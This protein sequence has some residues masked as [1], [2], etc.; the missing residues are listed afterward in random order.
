MP[1]AFAQRIPRPP[2]FVDAQDCR[3]WLAALSGEHPARAH[4]A[5]VAESNLL[6]AQPLAP[7]ERL[8]ILELLREAAHRACSEAARRFARRALPLAASEKAAFDANVALARALA[9]GYAICLEAGA[10]GQSRAPGEAALAAQRSLATLA[11]EQLDA[12]RTGIESAPSFWRAAHRIYSAAEALGVAE[13]AVEDP[14]FDERAASPAA[15][16]AYV[17]LLHRCDAHELEPSEFESARRHLARWSR[18]LK[19]SASPPPF[20]RLP[21]LV[22]DCAGSRP[23]SQVPPQAGRLRYLDTAPLAAKLKRRLQATADGAARATH[24]PEPGFWRHLYEHCCKGALVRLPASGKVGGDCRLVTGLD[25]AHYYLSGRK[26]F[27]EPI[28]E[29]TLA[30]WE[31]E[32]IA[33]LRMLAPRV[34]NGFSRS[35]GFQVETWQLIEASGGELTLFRPPDAPGRLG[36]G[37]LVAIKGPPDEAYVLAR[38]HWVRLDAQGAT[39]ARVR[40]IPG[41]P[42]PA[43]IRVAPAA[44]ADGQWRPGFVVTGGATPSL[45]GPRGAFRPGDVIDLLD[46]GRR[47][48]KL[49]AFLERGIDFERGSLGSP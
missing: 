35:R 49:T 1:E 9:K 5:L 39:L 10:P 33:T 16:Y 22:V 42:R 44:R 29:A 32:K 19:F 24:A 4:A 13:D 36:R 46:N 2:A 37:Q 12:C 41:T 6:N 17:L 7:D 27:R 40:R 8:R 20:F 31:V 34:E 48:V 43:A 14:L 15:V 21:P 38:V 47:S 45:V 30:S 26:P 25:A 18:H 3:R 28:D 11:W 23:P